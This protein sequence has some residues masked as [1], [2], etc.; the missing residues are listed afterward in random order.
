MARFSGGWIKL[1][2]SAVNEDLGDD[3]VTLAIWVT[4]L[5]WANWETGKTKVKSQQVILEPGQLAT[6]IR[7]L[8]SRLDVPQTTAFRALKY[9]EKTERIILKSGTQGS[10]IT[11]C[12]W[13]EYQQQ[14]EI[15]ERKR[16]TDGTQT[17]RKRNDNEEG[18]NLRKKENSL[19]AIRLDYPQ[20]FQSVWVS[21]GK[22]GQ[23]KEAFSSF[24]KSSLSE[25]ERGQLAG[26]IK[27]Y[28]KEN[29]ERKYRMSFH[30]FLETDWREHNETYTKSYD[31]Y[32][33]L[34]DEPGYDA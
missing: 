28:V 19:V 29:P 4:L 18:K 11:I 14:E 1:Y 26:A 24:Q 22:P 30:K 5:C 10:I 6:G 8:A 15:L 12:N 32:A 17:E 27:N 25:E 7:E 2:R 23:K 13:S 21:Y 31:R 9:L 3:A 33:F 34:D 16:N 20:E